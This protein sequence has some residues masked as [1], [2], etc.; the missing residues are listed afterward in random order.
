[1]IKISKKNIGHKNE[2]FIVAEMSGN[3]NQSLKQAFKII[4]EAKKCGV[5]AIKLQTY[6]ADTLT[7]NSSKKDFIIKDKKSLWKNQQLY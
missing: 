5:D 3:H 1:M 7:I 6:T 4:D 2:P